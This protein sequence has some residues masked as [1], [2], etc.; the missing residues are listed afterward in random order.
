MT[1]SL[2]EPGRLTASAAYP[3][4]VRDARNRGGLRHQ[5]GI[6][7]I[8]VDFP[9][10]GR[11]D[12]STVSSE[13][14]ANVTALLRAW[15]EGDVAAGERLIP[16][17]YQQL[18]RR[19]SAYLRRERGDHT[20]QATA[21]VHEA[22]LRMVDQRDAEWENRAQFFGVASQMMRR[23]LVDHARRRKMEKR[24][25]Q[26]MRVSLHDHAA[27]DPGFDV[28]LLDSLLDRLSAFDPRKSRVV[29]LRYFGGLTLQETAHVL[30]VSPAT[31]DREWRAA[32]AWL[33]AELTRGS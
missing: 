8:R 27:P 31:I 25:G 33:R 28:L 22:Y 11:Q 10:T 2:L 24:S 3:A 6:G 4:P 5:R 29:E 12:R 21:L 17:V 13:P 15:R 7:R 18:R 30:D 23:I 1:A 14:D 32:R 19:A 20:L 26:W 9:K 16:L